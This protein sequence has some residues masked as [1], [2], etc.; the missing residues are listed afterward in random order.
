MGVKAAVE[1]LAT[2][3]YGSISGSYAEVT[4]FPNAESIIT[5]QNLTNA[6]C[7]FSFDGTDDNFVLPA[8]SAM[9]IDVT[10]NHA[11]DDTG[12]YFPKNTRVYVR[13]SG[14]PSSGAVYVGAIYDSSN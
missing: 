10:A 9:I 7:F 2:L 1:T 3:A 12:L 4:T 14:S 11:A 13:T 8:T 6:T 5:L